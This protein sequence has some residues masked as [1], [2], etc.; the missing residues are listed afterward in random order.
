MPL[1]QSNLLEKYD[2]LLADLL[3]VPKNEWDSTDWVLF[4]CYTEFV[5]DLVDYYSV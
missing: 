4:N 3:S 1:T 5:E 2:T